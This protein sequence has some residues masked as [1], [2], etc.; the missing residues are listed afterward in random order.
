[1]VA[2]AAVDAADAG[3]DKSDP[4]LQS[5]AVALSRG[6]AT[7]AV[8]ESLLAMGTCAMGHLAAARE[9]TGCGG[10]SGGADHSGCGGGSAGADLGGNCGAHLG[11]SG[12]ADLGGSGGA[13]LGGSGGA[14]LGADL[15]GSGSSSSGANLVGGSGSGSR[16]PRAAL[17]VLA[18]SA[19][20]AGAYLRA[21][22]RA[23]FDPFDR[24]PAEEA[25]KGWR[26]PARMLKILWNGRL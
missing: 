22:E 26:G 4:E 25:A 13:H 5:V 21:T 16:V 18:P 15:G 8:R 2:S 24:T 10:G 6:Q 20:W 9:I 19:A 1:M 14:D 7:G 17:L 12:G 11:G 3:T 23:D